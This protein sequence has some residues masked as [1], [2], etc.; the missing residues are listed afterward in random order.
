M[1]CWYPYAVPRLRGGAVSYGHINDINPPVGW[2]IYVPL[3]WLN[4]LIGLR[5][6]LAYRA[7]LASPLSAISAWFIGYFSTRVRFR[8]PLRSH[9]PGPSNDQCRGLDLKAA[10]GLITTIRVHP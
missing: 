4:A 7:G 9:K 2:L 5:I 3:N 8:E 10:P 6:G 1:S